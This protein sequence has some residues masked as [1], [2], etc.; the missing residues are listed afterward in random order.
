MPIIILV[1]D[2][3][4]AVRRVTG[5]Y[6][7]TAGFRCLGAGTAADALTLL[8]SGR[9]PDL[10]VIDVR[11]PGLSG[12][13]LALEVHAR[14][15]SIPVLFVSAWPDTRATVG[16]AQSLRWDFLPKPYT[17]EALVGAVLGLLPPTTKAPTSL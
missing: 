8:G 4:P 5:I 14:Y 6:L 17:G 1:V 3:E 13:E 7:E 11:L 16:D 9:P 2:D 15:P 12:P 10:M